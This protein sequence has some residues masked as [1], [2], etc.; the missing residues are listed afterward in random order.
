MKMDISK[1][2]NHI[3]AAAMLT[4]LCGCS[5]GRKPDYHQT[6]ASPTEHRMQEAGLDVGID[7]FVDNQRSREYFGVNSVSDGIAIL[8]VRIRNESPDQ[9]FL[10]EKKNFHLTLR[11]TAGD[12]T[13]DGKGIDRNSGG[14]EAVA[15]LGAA[16]GSLPLLFVGASMVASA[17]EVQRNFVGKEMPD[18]T[19]APGQDMEGFIYYNL[20]PKGKDWSDGAIVTI[21]LP[22]T[23]TQ[24]SA[25]LSI[26]LSK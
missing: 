18:Q 5:S 7:P 15:W 21:D 2:L 11:N 24:Q 19:L 22:K 10:V 16:G 6:V 14:G 3:A 23:A 25:K 8:H 17:T 20:V 1:L 4:L 13:A 26:A 9:T 12:R